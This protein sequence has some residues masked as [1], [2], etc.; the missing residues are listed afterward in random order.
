MR[1]ALDTN[2]YRALH[3]GH[4]GLAAAAASAERIGLPIIVIGELR[5]GFI[6]GSRLRENTEVLERL[7]RE[8]RVEVLHVDDETTHRFGEIFAELRRAGKPM[9]Q[10]DVWIAALCRQNRFTLA[11]RD[12]AFGHVPGLPVL[13]LTP[14]S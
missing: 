2:A 6:H 13:D 7:I 14:G 3:E 12:R 4:A 9:Q 5:Y 8:P 11:T 10:N 1:L